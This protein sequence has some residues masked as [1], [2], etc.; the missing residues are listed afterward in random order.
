MYS[1]SKKKIPIYFITNYCTEIK[2]LPIIMNY[3]LLQFDALK[4]FLGVCLK[5]VEGKYLYAK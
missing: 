1:R 2:L 5:D 3:C 4:F